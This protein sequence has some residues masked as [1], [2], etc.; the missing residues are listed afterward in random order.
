MG[1]TKQYLRY[2]PGAV[3]GVVASQKSNV[4]FMDIKGTRGRYCAVGTCEDVIIWDVRT[5]EKVR[6]PSILSLA[7]K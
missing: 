7:L 5:G 4:V 6:M 3:F 1:L 2:V